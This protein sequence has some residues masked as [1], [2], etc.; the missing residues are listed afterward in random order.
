MTSKCRVSLLRPLSIP[1]LE[2][3]AAVLGSR[4]SVMIKDEH[5]L[6]FDET[7]YRTDSRTV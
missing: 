5:E 7:H 3:Q 6:T 4:L 1:R 2:L